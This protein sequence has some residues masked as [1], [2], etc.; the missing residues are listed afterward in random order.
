MKPV[1]SHYL[2]AACH[3]PSAGGVK[4][5]KGFRPSRMTQ[6]GGWPLGQ[7]KG[8]QRHGQSWRQS[9][10]NYPGEA[11][12]LY[13]TVLP[14][15]P[16]LPGGDTSWITATATTK[17]RFPSQEQRD[18]AAPASPSINCARPPYDKLSTGGYGEV[19]TVYVC[20]CWGYVHTMRLLPDN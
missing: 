13:T 14:T 8:N 1:T 18:G 4:N 9:G 5:H 2:R 3:G 19:M 7:G 12:Q 11:A 10:A 15:L 20:S 6:L 17:Q 16:V